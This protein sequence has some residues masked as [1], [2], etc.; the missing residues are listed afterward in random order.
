[1][2]DDVFGEGRHVARDDVFGENADE[3][4]RCPD[5]DRNLRHFN[6]YLASFTNGDANRVVR[7]SSEC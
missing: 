5:L 2:K 1:M 6:A 7:N 4:K 3:I